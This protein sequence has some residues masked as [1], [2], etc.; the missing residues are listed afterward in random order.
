MK[1]TKCLFCKKKYIEKDALLDHIN[2]THKLDLNGLPAA[3][4]YFNFKNRYALTR[5]FGKC[6]MTGKTTK[7]NLTTNRYERFAD[8][9]ARLAYREYF[10]KNMISKYGK[11]TILDEPEQQKKMLSNRS[12]SGIYEWSNGEKSTYTGSY[13]REFL[14]WLDSYMGWE[15]P[16]DIMSPAPMT[17]PYKDGDNAERFHIPDFYITSMNLIV[18]VKA[19]TNNHYRLR[20]IEDEKAQDNAIKASKFNYLKLYD[21]KFEKFT[22]IVDMIKNREQSKNE[23]RIFLE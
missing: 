14:E 8:E 3:Q 2:K 12:I 22:E 6:V 20:D 10:R 16:G 11:D 15:N 17:F 7:F 1:S 19:S 4:V 13:E 18:N 21:N 9:N 5:E 23:S